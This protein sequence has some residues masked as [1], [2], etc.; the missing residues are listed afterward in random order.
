MFFLESG[1]AISTHNARLCI[2]MLPALILIVVV[3][4]STSSRHKNTHT[5]RAKNVF[6]PPWF[7]F[8]PAL[9]LVLSVS[10]FENKVKKT[11][12]THEQQEDTSCQA[13]S[14]TLGF[15]FVRVS[16]TSGEE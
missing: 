10:L 7:Q 14:Q 3:L 11:A 15:L 1:R 2:L 12:P 8:L 16:H 9:F 5:P 6:F 13:C 4:L